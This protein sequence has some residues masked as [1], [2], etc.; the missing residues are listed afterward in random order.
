MKRF[1]LK[2]SNGKFRQQDG[3]NMTFD[4]M[5]GIG[6]IEWIIDTKTGE[7]MFGDKDEGRHT[8][9]ISEYSAADLVINKD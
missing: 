1:I 6:V 5:L 9:K 3:I 7:L 8:Q 4:Y 2:Y